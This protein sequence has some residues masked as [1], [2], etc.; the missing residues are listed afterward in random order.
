LKLKILNRF[1]GTEE[2]GEFVD[3]LP[4]NG[5]TSLLQLLKASGCPTEDSAFV[6]A[7][8]R[9]RNAYA[10]NIK[11]SELA[12][13]Q[14]IKQRPDKSHI[15]KTICNIKTYDE[16]SLIASYERDGNFLR[17]GILDA[18]MRILFYAYHIAMK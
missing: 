11:L 12:L 4:M 18:T 1:V 3:G 9:V 13:I 6:E 17:F 16:D 8:R 5:K 2:L 15:V 7:V 10:H 14:V